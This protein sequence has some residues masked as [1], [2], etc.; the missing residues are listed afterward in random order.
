[1]QAAP[2]S[3]TQG[4]SATEHRPEGVCALPV[5]VVVHQTVRVPSCTT[6]VCEYSN[7]LQVER[8]DAMDVVGEVGR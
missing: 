3:H 5:A 8:F 6:T 2:A 4:P 1:M 7:A